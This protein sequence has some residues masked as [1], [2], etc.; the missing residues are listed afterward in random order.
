MIIFYDTSALME[1]YEFDCTFTNVIS[2]ITIQELEELKYKYSKDRIK[3]SQVQHALSLIANEVKGEDNLRIVN[4][5]HGL[6]YKYF[7][8]KN[9]MPDTNDSKIIYDAYRLNKTTNTKVHFTTNDLAQSVFADRIGDLIVDYGSVK[10]ELSK[11]Q[12]NNNGWVHIVSTTDTINSCIDNAKNPFDLQQNEYINFYN[13]NTNSNNIYC[14]NGYSYSNLEYKDIHSHFMGDIKPRNDEQKMLFN[15]LQN[16]DIKVKTVLGKFGSGKTYIMLAHAIDMVQRGKFDK[17]VFI[18]NNIQVK[19]TKDIGSLPGS[20]FDKTLPYLMPIADHVG[21][22]DGLLDL[23]DNH[24]IEP[25]HLGFIRG[26]DFKRSIIF[27]D[28]CENLTKQHIQLI[29]GRAAEGSQVWFAGDLK[30]TDNI[31][32]EKNSG[33]IALIDKLRGHPLFGMVRLV[34]SE[35]SEIAQLAD[36]LD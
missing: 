6:E 2:A 34:K 29:L 13:T 21:G 15:L 1:E 30:Q 19:D 36:E 10:R 11:D 33:L 27:C 5:R 12:T 28:E 24:I 25:V 17:I 8:Y 23:I 20:E 32:F 22:M 35:R 7:I 3:L 26:R 16:Y 9:K 14:W 18:R 4:Y 31:T